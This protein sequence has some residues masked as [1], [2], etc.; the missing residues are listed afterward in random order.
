MFAQLGEPVENSQNQ[1]LGP[2]A[3]AI[4]QYF[5]DF[6]GFKEAFRRAV[7]SRALP[8]WVWLGVADEGRLLIT[9]TNNEDNPLMHGVVDVQCV[10]ICGIDLWEHAYLQQY[11]GSKEAYVDAFF[12]CI[13]W[14]VVSASFE[15]YN[16]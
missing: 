6:E 1:P 13:Q 3:D 5:T 15:F 11:G 12:Q 10:P 16:S 2:L 14:A 7:Y 8:G 9:Q 4:A